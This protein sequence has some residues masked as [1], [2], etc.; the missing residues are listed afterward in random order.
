VAADLEALLDDVVSESADLTGMLAGTDPDVW[1]TPTP[2]AGWSVGDQV[3]HL[4][5]FDREARRALEDPAG[6]V[7][8]LDAIAS[9]FDGYLQRHLEAGR[10]LG[11]QRLEAFGS[12]RWALVEALRGVDPATRV[13]WYGP[14]MS[15][16]SFATARLMETWAHGQDVADALGVR[17]TPTDR[18]RHICHLGVSTRSFS[19]AIRGESPPEAPIAVALDTPSGGVWTWGD[20][21]AAADRVEG[22]AE[23]FCLVV[24]QRRLLDDVDLRVTG[25]AAADWM[26]KA[27]A[28]AGGP[29]STDEN[30]RTEG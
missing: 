18:L 15:P 23:D 9:D 27:Q 2:A 22:P 17:R 5:F 24:T 13:P 6:F 26:A 21:A 11:N 8:G 10:A 4:W 30:R 28:F 12:E 14:P 7:A 25:A 29:T 1:S 19:Y 20:A 16:A 3:G